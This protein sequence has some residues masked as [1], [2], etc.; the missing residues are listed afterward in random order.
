MM[1]GAKYNIKQFRGLID[2]VTGVKEVVE[3]ER[4]RNL[5]RQK[6]VEEQFLEREG[7]TAAI[8]KELSLQL[9]CAGR[10]YQSLL[11]A[12][13]ELSDQLRAEELRRVAEISPLQMEIKDLKTQLATAAKPWKDEVAR[14]DVRIAKLQEA[15]LEQ[16]KRLLQA[17]AEVVRQQ[18]MFKEELSATQAGMEQAVAAMDG[19]RD[20]I[21]VAE[22]KGSEALEVEQA[23]NKMQVAALKVKLE[24]ITD[25]S[26]HIAGPYVKIIK[27][28][29]LKVGGLEQQLGRVDYGPLQ[30]QLEH[31]ELGYQRLIQDFQVKERQNAE[32]HEQVRANSEAIVARLEKRIQ[33]LE[34]EIGRV[35]APW[36]ET[37]LRKEDEI[38]HLHDKIEELHAAETDA[39]Q[40]E[41]ELMDVLKIE[42]A[43]A[44]AGLEFANKE[45]YSLKREMDA[46]V[47][48][49]VDDR[50]LKKR[51]QILELK[52]EEV[53]R[54][55]EALIRQKD[56]EIE[57][58]SNLVQRLQVRVL[59]STKEQEALDAEWDR[60]VQV[61]EEGYGLV[62]AQLKYAESQI[63]EERQR[64]LEMEHVVK[65]R[66]VTIQRLK[67]EHTEE[68]R[69]RLLDREAL[70][71]EIRRLEAEVQEEM[72]KVDGERLRQEVIADHIQRRTDV[73]LAD[74]HIE[75]ERKDR[76]RMEVD[77]ELHELRAAWAKS[78]T[79]FEEK[80]RDLEA[81]IRTRD[82][83]LASM[84][85]ELEFIN[86]SWEIKYLR[87]M[88][89]FEKLQRRYT[90]LLGPNGPVESLNRA[91]DLKAENEKMHFQIQE[92][93]ELLKKQKRQIR[94]LQLD[95]D[96]RMKETADMI[97]IKERGMVEMLGE[98]AKLENRLRDENFLREQLIKQ[99]NEEKKAI[100]E[101]FQARI[102][103]LE[104]LVEAMRYTDRQELVDRIDIWKRAYERVCVDRDEMEDELKKII[105][106]KELQLRK[107]ADDNFE[108][109]RLRSIDNAAYED[110]LHEL[111]E[112]WK[113][114][115][116][117][118]RFEQ[119]KLEQQ[120]Q[121]LIAEKEKLQR[122][123][124]R[125]RHL[126]DI[127]QEDPEKELFRAK[128]KEQQEQIAALEAG[129][130][131][132]IAEN[133]AYRE[134]IA[135]L[136]AKFETAKDDWE[137]QIKWRDDR[138]E[139]M[140][141]EHERIKEVL[142]L[143]VQKAQDNCKMIEEEVR[144]FPSPFEAELLELKDKYAQTQAGLMTMGRDNLR[145][146]EELEV[147]KAAAAEEVARLEKTIELAFH[148]LKEVASLGALKTLLKG[149][150]MKLSTALGMDLSGG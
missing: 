135:V 76:A 36:K 127:R 59:N 26:S 25:A 34:L 62:V 83:A 69:V 77:R 24:E 98:F 125:S 38:E 126:A 5:L 150:V 39:R 2:T 19:I 12:T 130:K 81:I 64:V 105:D 70:E 107:M 51:A 68:L 50:S 33:E 88:S 100:V 133:T 20:Q 137:P 67:L 99:M 23:R 16:E 10:S 40:H 84:Q 55:C 7:E 13:R 52:L 124:D 142:M 79:D 93:K 42:L 18:G 110:R 27:E 97:M 128:I 6:A 119:S 129:L 31:R 118:W 66:D 63:L 15:A 91:Q 123:L 120:I 46:T 17:M 11:G 96:M 53:T 72:A 104:Q 80:I 85:N 92:F 139:A 57:E 89:L 149:D 56:R 109:Q 102:E 122:D 1:G 112:E 47:A 58:K 22:D 45:A 78:R 113:R 144:K 136:N 86:D 143:E 90:D 94:D 43:A 44:K 74:L 65:R 134:E 30:K 147:Q 48:E 140:V 35:E 131:V 116:H 114:K 87:L 9:R 117:T 132:L 28:L 8:Q 73:R 75:L 32:V 54:Q 141:K 60:R 146:R 121:T 71:A 37:V 115:Q 21:K 108:E 4:L 49:V 148:I 111:N 41:K 103:Q 3:G 29:E 106:V 138:H 14:R 101:S 95:M 82:R 61:K 145:I